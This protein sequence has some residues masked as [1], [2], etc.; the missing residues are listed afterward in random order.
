MSTTFL[1]NHTHDRVQHA[2][3]VERRRGGPM[4][5]SSPLGPMESVVAYVVEIANQIVSDWPGHVF[6]LL[7][8]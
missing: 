6:S 3:T 4:S 7:E 8:R 2:A 5:A 1:G